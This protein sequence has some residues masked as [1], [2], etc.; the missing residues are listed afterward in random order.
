M[1]LV[2]P[3]LILAAGLTLVLVLVWLGQRRLIYLPDRSAVPPAASVFGGTGRDVELTTADGLVLRGWLVTPAP[4]AD[5]HVAVL[6]APG[7]GGNR[8]GRAP[9][10]EALADE[11]LTV[12]LLDYRGYGG[13]P[14]SPTEAGLYLDV[15]AARAYLAAAGWHPRQIV[16]FGESLGCA[17]VA[18]LAVE[19]PPGGILLR[20]PFTD[21]AAAGRHN[22]PYLPVGLLLRDRFPVAETMARVRVTTMVVYGTADS[23][24]P[25]EQS[26]EV[27]DRAAGEMHVVAVDGVDHND[28]ALFDG[29]PIVTAVLRLVDLMAPG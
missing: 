25:P 28:P 9:L 20:S 8:F 22:Y 17:M 11:G 18:N 12:L 2:R 7:N 16:Y 15:R 10:A 5:R 4:A 3:T 14:G 13:N 1:W 23:I 21:L 6:V 29:R 27:A 24:V 26:R 19:H